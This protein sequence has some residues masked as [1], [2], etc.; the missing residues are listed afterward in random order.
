MSY[1]IT[2]FVEESKFIYLQS[3]DY[4]HSYDNDKEKLINYH[5]FYFIEEKVD[6]VNSNQF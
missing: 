2:S 4:Q 5:Q 3:Y 1:H 6:G